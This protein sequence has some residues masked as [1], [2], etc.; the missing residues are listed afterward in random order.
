MHS[1]EAAVHPDVNKC[2]EARIQAVRRLEPA[3][4]RTVVEPC[5][6]DHGVIFDADM[7]PWHGVA[8]AWACGRTSRRAACGTFS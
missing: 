3:I 8:R 5:G 6:P 4:S 7:A 2:G 1:R